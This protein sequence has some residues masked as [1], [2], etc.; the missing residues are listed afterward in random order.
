MEAV[1]SGTRIQAGRCASKRLAPPAGNVISHFSDKVIEFPCF[2]VLFYLAI[3][4]AVWI[5]LI[6]AP[7]PLYSLDATTLLLKS[8]RSSGFLLSG[9]VHLNPIALLLVESAV[10]FRY[11]LGICSEQIGSER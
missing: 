2:Q 7:S 9:R 10:F 8:T 3:P 4:F 1:D 6:A 5:V 11:D